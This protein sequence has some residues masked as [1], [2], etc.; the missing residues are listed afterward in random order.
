MKE[1]YHCFHLEELKAMN[2]ISLNKAPHCT[3][4]AFCLSK[5]MDW[6]KVKPFQCMM[7]VW[8]RLFAPTMK[9]NN[10]NMSLRLTK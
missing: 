2:I 1:N 9:H 10:L 6:Q 3:I 8:Q 4:G 5:S 7:L